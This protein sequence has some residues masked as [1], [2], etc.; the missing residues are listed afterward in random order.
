[1]INLILPPPV[2]SLMQFAGISVREAENTLNNRHRGL[3]DDGL[4]RIIAAHWVTDHRII[5]LDGTVTQLVAN[6]E[7]G[8][9]K[10]KDV[11]ANL[12]L[13]LEPHLP[14]GLITRDMKMVD[15]LVKVADAFGHPITASLDRPYTKLYS[16]KWDGKE[17][18]FFEPVPEAAF[19]ICGSFNGNDNFANMLWAFNSDAYRE[20]IAVKRSRTS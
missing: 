15:I 9:V 20:W 1:M 12:V 3:A 2:T 13:L 5:F 7:D 10:L 4:T 8:Q 14:S 6:N 19:V 17:I 18:S 11:T 16:N